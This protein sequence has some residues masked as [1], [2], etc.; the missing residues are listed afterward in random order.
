MSFF[1]SKLI[2]PW[3]FKKL[4]KFSSFHKMNRSN[5]VVCHFVACRDIGTAQIWRPKISKF[6]RI[7]SC[8]TS[9]QSSSKV[10]IITGEKFSNWPDIQN[11][12]VEK[13]YPA[14]FWVFKSAKFWEIS[15]FF[16]DFSN[17][18]IYEPL[19][20]YRWIFLMP[21]SIF[22]FQLTFYWTFSVDN[23]HISILFQRYMD[24]KWIHWFS[25]ILTRPN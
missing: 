24:Q 8:Y 4:A 3:P 25:T 7:R 20:I 14:F 6:E 15:M 19:S 17:G 10:H 11:K 1:C 2:G 23:R 9:L 16:H 5:R 18:H 13:C 21:F 22:Y 12:A